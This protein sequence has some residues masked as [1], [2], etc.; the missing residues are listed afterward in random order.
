MRESLWSFSLSVYAA[1]SVAAA[2]LDAQ[3]GHDADVNLLLW[4]AWLAAQ[5]HDLMPDELAE[6]QAATAPWRDEVVRPLRA[7]RRRLKSAPG[8]DAESLRR[9]VKAAELEAERIQQTVLENLPERRR[10]GEY[11]LDLLQA[12][13]SLL[14]PGDAAAFV[15]KPLHSAIRGD[16]NAVIGSPA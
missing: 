9:Q 12:N 13:L 14:L 2:C 7:V 10:T 16:R 4:A 5:G 3:D 8:P 1:P 15:T 11:R 6:A